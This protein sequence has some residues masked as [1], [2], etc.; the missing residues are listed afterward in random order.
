MKVLHV[1][2]AFP[3]PEVPEYG[4]FVQEQIA[5]LNRGGI[6][7]DVFFVNA[8]AEGKKAYLS[9][10]GPLREKAKGYDI[11]HCHH[12]YSSFVAALARVRQPVVVSFQNDWLREVEIENRMVQSLLCHLGVRLADRVIFKSPIPAQFRGKP[13]FVHLPNGVNYDAFSITDKAAARERMGLDPHAVYALFV[14]SKDKLRPQKRYDRFTETLAMVRSRNP[15]MDLR[16]LVM[17][18]QPRERVSDFFN[19]A[20]LHLLCSDYEGSPNSVKE[21]LCTGLPVVATPAGNTAE[22]IEG[23]PGCQIASAFD[24]AELARLVER[25]V[26]SGATRQAVRA[27]FLDKGLSQGAVTEKLKQLYTNLAAKTAR[28]GPSEGISR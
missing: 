21:A 25:S 9:A 1:T 12:V 11:I 24:A 2:N 10:V 19:A 16:E 20:D 18:N 14:S 5:A 22:M 6:E 8:R 26:A 4:V 3:Y 13:K 27:G 23:I 17:V 28:R 15:G 7:C